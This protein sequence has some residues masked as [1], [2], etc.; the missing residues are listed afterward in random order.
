M[1]FISLLSLERLM[2]KSG[3]KRVS[4]ESKIAMRET[5]ED[6]AEQ[7]TK[8][9]MMFAEHAKR[10]TIKAEDIKLALKNLKP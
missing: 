2:K 3:A 7:L 9:A 4:E 5:L 10:S 1:A 6:F 8:K